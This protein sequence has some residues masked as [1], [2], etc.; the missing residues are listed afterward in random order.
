VGYPLEW[1]PKGLREHLCSQ[2]WVAPDQ[3]T[4][5]IIGDLIKLLDRHRPVGSDGKHANLHTETCGCE[6]K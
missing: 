5:D 6:D 3:E 2:Q 1:H 4:K